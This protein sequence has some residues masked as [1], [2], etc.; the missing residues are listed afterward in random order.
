MAYRDNVTEWGFG[1]LG[2]GYLSDGGEF[3]PPTGLVVVA[4]TVV[5]SCKFEELVQSNQDGVAYF[6]GEAQTTLNGTG[7]DTVPTSE[8]FPAG[9]TIYGRWSK[10]ELSQGAAILYFGS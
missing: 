6:G 10:V 3:T 4:I 5:L 1:Q 8:L 9:I 2:S 7:S